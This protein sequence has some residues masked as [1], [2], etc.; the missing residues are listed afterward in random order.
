MKQ[1]E[2]AANYANYANW[3]KEVFVG[4]KGGIVDRRSEPLSFP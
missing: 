3:D 4:E 2:L 1:G